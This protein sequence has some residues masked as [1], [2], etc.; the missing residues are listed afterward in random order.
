[1]KAVV[2]LCGSKLRMTNE[3]C[4]LVVWVKTRHG[5]WKLGYTSLR[6]GEV[7]P[8]LT[9][10]K[11]EPH[12]AV[13]LLAPWTRVYL[14]RN[15]LLR[16]ETSIVSMSI[17]WMSRKPSKAYK[18]SRKSNISY[19]KHLYHHTAQTIHCQCFYCVWTISTYFHQIPWSQ[20]RCKHF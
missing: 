12:A 1:M 16:L 4:C 14:K 3:S 15:C 13:Q 6:L 11:A 10:T 20:S 19:S 18:Q 8:L 9:F 5:Q 2:W 17:T 7:M